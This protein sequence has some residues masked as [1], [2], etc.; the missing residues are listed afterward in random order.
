MKSK[1][2]K[3]IMFWGLGI[4]GALILSTCESINVSSLASAGAKAASG[5]G[6]ISDNTAA[7]ISAT[8]EAIGKALEDITPEQEYYIGRAVAAN[9]L[10]HYRIFW[11]D[12]DLTAYANKICDAI[13]INSPRPD[14]FNGYH[15]NILDSTE[16]NA[17]ATSGGHIFLTRGLIA[18]ADSEDVLAGVIAHEVAHIQ[19][20]HSLKAIKNSRFNA[21]ILATGVNTAGAL[22]GKDVQELTETFNESVGDI[23]NTMLNS[24]YSRQQEYDADATALSLMAGAGYE[25]S[26]LVTML[27]SLQKLE[28]SHPGGFNDTHPSPTDRI[29]NVER[30]L[31]QYH[32]LDT[33]VFRQGR[34]VK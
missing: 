26:C 29:T 19:L 12:P 28:P 30:H 6:L 8:G 5:A 13:V 20:Q 2:T 15:L 10:T 16:I 11:G 22:T 33:R 3:G 24:G 32:V 25:P 31:G 7:A 9:I 4:L 23:V 14:I 17:F 34:F 21:A 1:K 27:L 18:C